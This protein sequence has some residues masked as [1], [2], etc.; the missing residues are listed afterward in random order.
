MKQY[1]LDKIR[2]N[3]EFKNMPTTIEYDSIDW[4][5]FIRF[6]WDINSNSTNL[7]LKKEHLDLFHR[8]K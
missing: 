7:K 6:L 2:K 1:V 3:E 4:R 5:N 8:W